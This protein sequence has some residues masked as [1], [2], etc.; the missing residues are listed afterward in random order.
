[1]DAA[2]PSMAGLPPLT[3]RGRSRERDVT[4]AAG[5]LLAPMEGVTDRCYRDLVLDVVGAGGRGPGGACT[6]FQRISVAPLPRRVFRRE[7]G[8]PP[9]SDVPVGVQLMAA[10]PEHVE[11]TVANAVAAG[12]PW[13]DLNFGCPVRRVFDKCAGSA[14]LAAPDALG[15]IVA[16]AAR[17]TDVPVT[18]KIRAGVD[19]D[20]RLD[21]VLDA[22]AAAGAAGVILHARLRRHSYAEPA[23]WEWIARA[24]ERLR[25]HGVPLVGNGGVDG[26]GDV[27]RM[28]DATGCAAV[29]IGRGALADPWIFRVARGG[30]P[31]TFDEARSFALRYLDALCPAGGAAG[32]LARFKQLLRRCTAGGFDRVVAPDLPRLLRERD[33]RVVRAWLLGA[34]AARTCG[35]T[36][37]LASPRP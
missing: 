23:R 36:A 1:M 8:D 25:P 29:M 12:A 2:A 37:G 18:A 16:A 35:R 30:P 34:G 4:F 21:D 7:L 22:C 5:V 19:D 33:P 14:L 13:I 20:A 9:R 24:A 17:A 3:L 27:A 10:G 31:A 28:L 6:E 26:A 32:P 15:A 11:R